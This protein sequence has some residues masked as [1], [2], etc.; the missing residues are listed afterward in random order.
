MAEST[1]GS[2]DIDLGSDQYVLRWILAH[3]SFV[4]EETD[5]SLHNWD[6]GEYTLVGATLLHTKNVGEPCKATI[7]FVRHSSPHEDHPERVWTIESVDPVTISPAIE[8]EAE[9]CHLKGSV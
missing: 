6:G 5:P 8:C 2:E 4:H 3:P 1:V 9:G 7:S